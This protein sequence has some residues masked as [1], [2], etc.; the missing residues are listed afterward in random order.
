MGTGALEFKYPNGKPPCIC[1]RFKTIEAGCK[2]NCGAVN[3]HSD[4][5]FSLQIHYGDFGEPLIVLKGGEME[6]KY[7][8]VRYDLANVYEFLYHTR[9]EKLFSFCHVIHEDGKEK[10]PKTPLKNKLWVLKVS[11]VEL[12]REL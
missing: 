12:F 9:H 10:I 6:Y 8:D 1:I 11:S 3:K 5:I 2:T 7:Y 4:T